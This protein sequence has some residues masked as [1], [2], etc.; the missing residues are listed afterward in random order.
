MPLEY[1]FNLSFDPPPPNS[2]IV[3]ITQ[4]V[5]DL[6][7]KIRQNPRME[8]A[9]SA[10]VTPLG[11]D[12]KGLELHPAMS[13][14]VAEVVMAHMMNAHFEIVRRIIRHA[15]QTYPF[16]LMLEIDMQFMLPPKSTERRSPP[17]G[18]SQN[19]VLYLNGSCPRTQ[20][21]PFD[22]K[23]KLTLGAIIQITEGFKSFVPSALRRTYFSESP[24][25]SKF[26]IRFNAK[27]VEQR[28]FQAFFTETVN[29]RGYPDK[30]LEDWRSY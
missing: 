24:I 17:K 4:E 1:R 28:R 12:F 3:D 7:A 26:V 11:L 14:K 25:S 27:H 18:P 13:T 21:P 16:P 2:C 8:L 9:L 6:V 10:P 15:P 30:L 5:Q 19:F 29:L 22:E 23:D 20:D